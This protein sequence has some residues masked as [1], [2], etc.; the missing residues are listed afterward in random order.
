MRQF[1]SCKTHRVFRPVRRG[2][3]QRN[4]GW[5]SRLRGRRALGSVIDLQWDLSVGSIV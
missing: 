2:R 1:A 4:A 3:G 5:R